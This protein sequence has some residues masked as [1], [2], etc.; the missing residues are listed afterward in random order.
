MTHLWCFLFFGIHSNTKKKKKIKN[1]DNLY[2]ESGRT[3][4][5]QNARGDCGDLH[6]QRYSKLT[7]HDPVQS[8]AGDSAL[9]KGIGLDY[10]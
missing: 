5:E 7:R 1:K 2:C 4:A 6:S 8:V 10:F 3:L 9:S